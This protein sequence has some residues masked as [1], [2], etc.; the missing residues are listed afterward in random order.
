VRRPI[1]LVFVVMLAAV[2]SGSPVQAQPGES[3]TVFAAASLSEAIREVGQ[4]FTGRTDVGVV[5]HTA[6]SNTLRLQIEQ[7]YPA[8]IFIAASEDETAA[9]A[10]QGLIEPGAIRTLLENHLVVIAPKDSARPLASLQDL[11]SSVA[12]YL[13]LAD[14]QTVPA[15]RYAREA[16]QAAGVWEPLK[17]RIAPAMDV[18]AATSLVASR[19]A[20][21]GIVYRTEAQREPR[22]VV[23][24]PVPDD[25]H[26]PI[27][28]TAARLKT[29]PHPDAADAF[30]EF[31][32]SDEAGQIF[33]QD[34]F[35]PVGR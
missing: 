13:A 1:L 18:R 21:F 7:K 22:V 29:A 4:V 23:V 35:E 19:S 9:L 6:G 5:V 31:L 27:R 3:I 24:M 16:L 8:D 20:D 10:A 33:T 12:G 34:G 11:P 32:F 30:Y 17:N 28:Y 15:G 2:V 14:P 25:V 26:R